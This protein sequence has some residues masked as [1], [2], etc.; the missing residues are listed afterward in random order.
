MDFSKELIAYFFRF[1]HSKNLHKTAVRTSHRAF[2]KLSPSVCSGLGPYQCCSRL[3]HALF[4][5]QELFYLVRITRPLRQVFDALNRLSALGHVE[6]RKFSAVSTIAAVVIFIVNKLVVYCR[7]PRMN[8]SSSS[9]WD[10]NQSD[11]LCRR[12]QPDPYKST[13]TLSNLETLTMATVTLF[14]MPA[15]LHYS[16]RPN[17]ESRSSGFFLFF[18]FF[19]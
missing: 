4:H 12:L 2:I 14:E 1:N 15:N 13:A 6:Q 5:L 16:T 17:S 11:I 9:V 19:L 10:G 3:F 18:S 8:R 7:D